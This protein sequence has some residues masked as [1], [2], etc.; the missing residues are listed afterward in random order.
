MKCIKTPSPI[1]K[2]VNAVAE[3]AEIRRGTRYAIVRSIISTSR[4]K[5]I[6][7]IGALKIPAIAPAAPQP[8][9][10]VTYL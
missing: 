6:P 8:T 2:E 5:T 10:K 7:A 9:I 3:T 4:V 1:K